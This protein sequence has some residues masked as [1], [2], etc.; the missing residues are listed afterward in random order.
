MPSCGVFIILKY[1]PC[2]RIIFILFISILMRSLLTQTLVWISYTTSLTASSCKEWSF[3]DYLFDRWILVFGSQTTILLLS[4]VGCSWCNNIVLITFFDH[5]E[6]FAD[7]PIWWL[8]C[9]IL[10]RWISITFLC[11][12]FISIWI[13]WFILFKR[14][15]REMAFICQY[16]FARSSWQRIFLVFFFRCI[17]SVSW[18]VFTRCSFTSEFVHDIS[19]NWF[20]NA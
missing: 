14:L 5:F 12:I 4:L 16:N 6:F 17:I 20:L 19:W 8:S 2:W 1:S 15:S 9:K 3:D 13:L 7:N 18:C 11:N 10:W